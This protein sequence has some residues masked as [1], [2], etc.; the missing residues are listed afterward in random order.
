MLV[1]WLHPHTSRKQRDPAD[2]PP[3]TLTLTL[4]LALALTLTLTLIPLSS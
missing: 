2:T 3:L 4:A 1:R